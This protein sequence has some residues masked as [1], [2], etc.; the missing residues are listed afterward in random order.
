MAK[1]NAATAQ[2]EDI[3]ALAMASAPTA[4]ELA[5]P[6]RTIRNLKM[7]LANYQAEH[8]A[9]VVNLAFMS[10]ALQSLSKRPTIDFQRLDGKTIRTR[11]Q[12]LAQ[13]MEKDLRRFK[14]NHRPK[15]SYTNPI[16]VNILAVLEKEKR[17][18]EV[19]LDWLE[20]KLN[21]DFGYEFTQTFRDGYDKEHSAYIFHPSKKR[22]GEATKAQF[23]KHVSEVRRLFKD[24]AAKK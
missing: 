9:Y 17:P 19:K 3:E 15:G 11:M 5:N 21:V 18:L 24:R 20:Y 12:R 2:D 16:K 22:L 10:E 23:A 6:H 1:K 14:K 4:D 7:M 8:T 13:E